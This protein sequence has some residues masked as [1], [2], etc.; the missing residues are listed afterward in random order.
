MC[1]YIE[2]FNNFLSQVLPEAMIVTVLIKVS[3][4]VGEVSQM[5]L[6]IS[7]ARISSPWAL[8]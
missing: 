6:A 4:W 5:V 8:Q 2:R 3:S 7:S 1:R